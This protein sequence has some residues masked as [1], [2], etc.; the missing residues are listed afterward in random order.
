MNIFRMSS[1]FTVNRLCEQCGNVF[2]TKTTVT[3]FCVSFVQ[4]VIVIRGKKRQFRLQPNKQSNDIFNDNFILL[5][6]NLIS[7]YINL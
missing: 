4:N 7:C 5:T 1:N 6:D 3:K 2:L